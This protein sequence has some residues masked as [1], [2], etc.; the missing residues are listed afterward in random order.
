MTAVWV[1]WWCSQGCLCV[2]SC[3]PDLWT[4]LGP[5]HHWHLFSPR[6]EH[7]Q[8]HLQYIQRAKNWAKILLQI[9]DMYD[10]HAKFGWNCCGILKNYEWSLSNVSHLL[11]HVR[12]HYNVHFKR[13]AWFLNKCTYLITHSKLKQIRT[14]NWKLLVE[15]AS[16]KAHSPSDS[17]CKSDIA[18]IVGS[19]SFYLTIRI[20]SHPK[21]K[22]KK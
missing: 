2:D 12:Q 3:Q 11:E 22:R 20:Y 4:V 15:W 5:S 21:H 13:N 6:L 18:N 1:W 14:C 7:L 10:N 9:I 17:N 8:R 16:L 19:V